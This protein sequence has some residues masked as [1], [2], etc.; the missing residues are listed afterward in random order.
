MKGNC[1][2]EPSAEA[3]GLSEFYLTERKPGHCILVT[4]VR[5][6]LPQQNLWLDSLHVQHRTT[7]RSD[8]IELLGCYGVSCRLWLTSITLR[9]DAGP[10]PNWG[11]INVGGGKWV[12]SI[13]VGQLYAEG[14]DTLYTHQQRLAI[15]PCSYYIIV[16]STT[17]GL[18]VFWALSRCKF[19]TFRSRSMMHHARCFVPRYQAQARISGSGHLDSAI[20]VIPVQG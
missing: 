1:E 16:P 3:L 4:D 18:I 9:G 12:K 8:T 14:T 13:G 7:E 20:F 15:M 17:V 6:M 2:T 5:L 19:T 11:G 10:T